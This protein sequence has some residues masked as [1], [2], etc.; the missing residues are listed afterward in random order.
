MLQQS[1][2]R[3]SVGSP[4]QRM[5]VSG[6]V[7]PSRYSALGG[8][9]SFQYM[10]EPYE[11]QERARNAGMRPISATSSV[12]HPNASP[13]PVFKTTA[14]PPAPRHAGAF[15]QFRYTIDPYENRD[16]AKREAQEKNKALQLSAA[17][18]AGGASK[19]NRARLRS[20]LPELR[21]QLL[22]TLRNDWG[23]FRKLSLDARGY[24][25]CHFAADQVS[26]ERA[27]DLHTYMNRVQAQH[28]AII[29]FCVLRDASR[30]GVAMATAEGSSQL[31][32]ALRPPWV[33]SEPAAAHGH[34]HHSRHAHKATAPGSSLSPAAAGGS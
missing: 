19:A 33:A 5:S 26:K 12:S 21:A 17:F 4:R 18:V 27:A 3:L 22:R 11:R 28:P 30:W 16:A 20:R 23:C 9:S 32:Y 24:L 13:R 2:P 1:S 31:V 29:E 15:Q 8:F 14:L 25:L 34:A 10:S 7:V 6:A